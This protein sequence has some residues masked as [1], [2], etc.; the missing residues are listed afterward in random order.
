MINRSPP[1]AENQGETV[2]GF[3]SIKIAG[4]GVR[5]QNAP[6][7]ERK[8]EP[9][10]KKKSKASRKPKRARG[11]FFASVPT[12]PYRPRGVVFGQNRPDSCVAACCRMLLH[13]QGIEIAESYIRDA[14]QI[15]SGSYVSQIPE[16]L[17]AFELAIQYQYRNNLTIAG[18]T[19][20]VKYGVAAAFV[21]TPNALDGHALLVDEIRDGLVAVR[22]P[23]PEGEGR[24][25]KV[26]VSNFLK[27]WIAPQ[28]GLGQATVVIK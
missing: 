26:S 21:K 27:F 10:T 1:N 11:Y 15:N 7:A 12:F 18:L 2:H 3:F 13:D 24:A 9:K 28:T 25:Y 20:A 19:D 16:T 5:G 22:D 23:L 4:R 14:L 8:R 17:Q 6:M